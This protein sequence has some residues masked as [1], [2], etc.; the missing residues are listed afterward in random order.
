[1]FNYKNAFS[2]NIGWISEDE[3]S[4]IENTQISIAGMGGVGGQYLIS[5]VRMG[6][7]NFRIADFDFF[8][9]HNFNR[10]YGASTKTI[11][12]AKAETMLEI[13]KDINPNVNIE[14]Y[15]DG[16]N[17][18]NLESFLKN[19]DIYIDGLDF[20]V[21]NIREKVFLK[22]AEMDI[23]AITVA[24]I[25]MGGSMLYFD[26][27][28]MSFEEYFSFPKES[29]LAEKLIY[30]ISGLDPKMFHSE[31]MINKE[32]FNFK[33]QKVSSNIAGIN[34]AAAIVG[35]NVFKLIA[36]R[37]DIVAAPNS[38]HFDA[39]LNNSLIVDLKEGNNNKNQQKTI[40]MLKSIY[41]K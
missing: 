7:Q 35:A 8:E 27:D 2:R 32:S 18:E 20:F 41:L 15:K 1:M 36:G 26:K 29:Q 3:Q 22:C 21:L 28:S 31:Y 34:M 25:G 40:E 6:F 12:K 16:V 9:E 39:F 5:L 10:Q 30:F 24:P 17:D 23:P 37:G 19:I 4:K 11:N 13:A 33:D 38:L 14:L